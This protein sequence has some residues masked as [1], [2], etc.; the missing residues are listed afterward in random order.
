M[1]EDIAADQSSAQ[2]AG[3]TALQGS[4]ETLE[5]V[6]SLPLSGETK[7]DS[8]SVWAKLLPY[9]SYYN[10]LDLVNNYTDDDGYVE[11]EDLSRNGTYI[12]GNKIGCGKKQV[13]KSNDEIALSSPK[14]KTFIYVALNNSDE[15]DVDKLVLERYTVCKVLGSG[16]YGTVRL[17][18]ER[19]TCKKFAIKI[20]QKYHFGL[21][22]SSQSQVM[23]E[24][25]L[26]K[27]VN[28]PCIINIEEVIDTKDTLYIVFNLIEGGDLCDRIS[29]RGQLK[30]SSAQ[31]ILYQ[32]LLAIQ[33]LHSQGICHRDLKPE[34]ILLCSDDEETLIK[35][36]DFGVSK[37]VDGNTMLKTFCGT[38]NYLA[39]EVIG[40][41]GGSRYT[42][43]VDCWSIGVILY[44]CLVGYHPFSEEI[45]R[46]KSLQSQ[47]C[48]GK[49]DF[50]N[51][52]WK[53]ISD[54]AKDL[55]KG[56]LKVVP[57]ERLSIDDALNHKWFKNEVILN[58]V[59][60]LM[61][62]KN[63]SLSSSP[64]SLKRSFEEA[65][66]S[67]IEDTSSSRMKTE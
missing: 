35:V 11:I 40:A 54:E 49:Y 44:C 53:N 41:N 25:N 60:K 8:D 45:D 55:V 28:H 46:N 4:A 10:S 6:D 26:L 34:N 62:G 1:N 67:E 66:N 65:T 20:I 64:M 52:Y 58:K 17:A 23:N 50:P 7:S 30:E 2:D 13:L 27:T 38:P 19:G 14:F 22:N 9:N 37:Y 12:N 33:Y 36:T 15:E 29:N 47:I 3:E 32:L 57:E 5:F 42:N 51:K 48:S 61:E 43:A 18:F 16:T 24:V 39:P 31:I 56:F 59:T 63:G 21:T